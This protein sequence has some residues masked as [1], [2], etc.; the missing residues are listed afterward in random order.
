[1]SFRDAIEHDKKIASE[2]QYKLTHQWLLVYFGVVAALLVAFCILMDK[3]EK[4]YLGVGIV[5]LGLFVLVT[6]AYFVAMVIVRKRDLVKPDVRPGAQ[7][8]G[9]MLL[10]GEKFKAFRNGQSDNIVQKGHWDMRRPFLIHLLMN[11]DI[12]PA[13]VTCLHPLTVAA[14][15]EPMDGTVLLS[16]PDELAAQYSLQVGDR[17]ITANC[18]YKNAFAHNGVEIDIFPGD[19]RVKFWQDVCPIVPLF[20]TDSAEE[21]KIA[22]KKISEQTWAFA[23][24][25]V[26]EHCEQ[27]SLFTRDGFWFV[28]LSRDDWDRDPFAESEL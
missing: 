12:Q 27:F 13:I 6:A 16:F 15:N 2:A 8:S 4:K 9:G 24:K 14:Y 5:L 25:R 11:G 17:L 19:R 1:M 22:E 23:E 3:D 18:Y 28:N 7:T 20:F 26:K 10:S 21:L